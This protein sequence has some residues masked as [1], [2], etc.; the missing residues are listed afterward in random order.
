MSETNTSGRR[1]PAESESHRLGFDIIGGKP[2][3]ATVNTTPSQIESVLIAGPPQTG[4]YELAV[5][6]LGRNVDGAVFATNKY[7]AARVKSDFADIPTEATT[8]HIH[9]VESTTRDCSG[10]G[11]A[12]PATVTTTGQDTTGLGVAITDAV[13]AVETA[14]DGRLGVGIDSLTH[15]LLNK[16]ATELY[17]FTR[18][19]VDLART[20]DSIAIATVDTGI[21]CGEQT[22]ALRNYFDAVIE[23]RSTPERTY[24]ARTA[25]GTGDWVEF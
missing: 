18:A 7:A 12:D 13:E 20:A 1:A 14:T 25:A 17:Q 4:K 8:S 5:G 10:P 6:S 19:Y 23:T 21:G 2:F 22:N 16:E 11:R 9:V 3:E 15:T 24:R